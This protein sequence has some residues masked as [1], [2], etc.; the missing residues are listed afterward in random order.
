MMDTQT[1]EDARQAYALMGDPSC[2]E[3]AE[4]GTVTN[5]VWE[6]ALVR[7]RLTAPLDDL[8]EQLVLELE[9]HGLASVTYMVAPWEVDEDG[10]LL[11]GWEDRT[12]RE[13][14]GTL[15]IYPR[16]VLRLAELYQPG[17]TMPTILLLWRIVKRLLFGIYEFDEQPSR[18]V[19]E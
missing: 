19:A 7:Q 14:W 1:M 18:A 16:G 17:Q 5:V 2:T 11:P 10:N 4:D 9:A 12:V 6:E 15:H 8:W 13:D 3:H